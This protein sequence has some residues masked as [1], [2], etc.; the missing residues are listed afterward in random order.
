MA[1]SIRLTAAVGFLVVVL[2]G[3]TAPAPAS[4][5]CLS[6]M[7]AAAPPQAVLR[8]DHA[9]SRHDFT[10]GREDLYAIVRRHGTADAAAR[11][12]GRRV[13]GLTHSSLGYQL[14]GSFDAVGLP[15]GSWCLWPRSVEADLGYSDTTVYVARDYP[16]G[17]CAFDAVLAHEHEH[18]GIN[19]Q[20]VADHAGRLRDALL[21]LA[22]QGF[23]LAGPDPAVLR[24][25]GQAMMDAGF[26]DALT[27]LLA[28]RTR[29]N[30]AI[31]TE[32]S[33][34]ALNGRC[35]RW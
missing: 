30:A 12:S 1:D 27:P 16:P 4:Q 11:M 24:A 28:D 22:R 35:D 3:W 31:D 25:R 21:R 8:I 18:V 34:R 32:S 26:R 19:E 5:K 9:P 13:H 7:S 33:Y 15:D 14:Q 2:A 6:A 29:R 17:T 10:R 20:V 23:P